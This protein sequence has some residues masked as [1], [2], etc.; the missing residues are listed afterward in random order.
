MIYIYILWYNQIMNHARIIYSEFGKFKII[1][2]ILYELLAYI[3]LER[4]RKLQRHELPR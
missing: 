1:C 3:K 2:R 4:I